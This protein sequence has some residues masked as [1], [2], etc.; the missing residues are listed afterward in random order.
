[1]IHHKLK[2]VEQMAQGSGLS[3]V[4]EDLIIQGV[5][6]DS[7]TVKPG[8]LFVPI[9]RQL[10]GHDYVEEALSQGGKL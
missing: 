8:N 5:S 1:M 3:V 6:I 4:H 2:D 7:R 10:D 9:I